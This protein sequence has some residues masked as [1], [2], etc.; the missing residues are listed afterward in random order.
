MIYKTIAVYA[1]DHFEG[2]KPPTTYAWLLPLKKRCTVSG[3]HLFYVV[4][5]IIIRTS[6]TSLN[7]CIYSV[8]KGVLSSLRHVLLR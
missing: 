3:I 5:Q 8:T 4:F 1:L 7:N 2:K 6:W